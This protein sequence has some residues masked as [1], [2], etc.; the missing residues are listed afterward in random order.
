M[1]DVNQSN[2]FVT[3]EHKVP[4][5]YEPEPT[6]VWW[7]NGDHP[8]DDVYRPFE[9]TGK[10]PTEPRE[11]KV[12]RYFRHPSISGDSIC[13]NCQRIMND[14]GWIDNGGEG[15]K[16]CPGDWIDKNLTGR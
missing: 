13:D 14:H 1:N 3:E 7:K 9:D 10:K 8:N 4:T 11:G 6:I 16:V 2:K 5:N 12:V 15:Q